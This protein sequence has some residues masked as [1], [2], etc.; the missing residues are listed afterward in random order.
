MKK[1]F[2]PATPAARFNAEGPPTLLI[3]DR[4][5]VVEPAVIWPEFGTNQVISKQD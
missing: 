4:P 1:L 5:E 2:Y 3:Q